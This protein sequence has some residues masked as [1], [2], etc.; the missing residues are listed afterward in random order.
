MSSQINQKVVAKNTLMLYI[1]MSV[2]MI[3]SLYTSRIVLDILGLDDFG[4]YNVVGGVVVMFSFLNVTLTVAIRRFLAYEMGKNKND[5]RIQNVF[6]SCIIAVFI[7]SIIIVIGL[8]SMGLWFLNYQLN[9]PMERMGA[10]NFVFQFSILA[11]FFNLNLIPF[12]SAIVTYEKMDI[13]AYLGIIETL[14]KLALVLSLPILPGDKLK[15]YGLLILGLT[16]FIA[17]CNYM[18]CCSNIIRPISITTFHW[19]YVMSIFKFSAWTVLG[20]MVFM[21][22]TQGVNIIYNLF[23][24]V[25]INAALGIAQNVAGATGQF[26]A[27][28]QTAFNPQLIKIYSTEGLSENTF[29]FVCQTS[30][31]SFLL[32]LVIGVPIIANITPILDLWLVEVPVYAAI[33][34]VIFILNTSIDGVSGPLYLLVYAKGDLKNY[35][36]VL[37]AIQLIY[38]LTVLILCSLGLYPEVVLSFYI[39]SAMVVYAARLFI[40]KRIMHF[41]VYRFIREVIFPLIIPLIFLGGMVLYGIS[42]CSTEKLV[43]VVARIILMIVFVTAILYTVYLTKDERYFVSS[44]FKTVIH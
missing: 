41:P 10:A 3:I 30:R 42:Y 35:Q 16:V 39:V 22:S 4:I 8:E 15:W 26:I 20:S 1:R 28:F 37:S 6:N 7:T 32:V 14:L 17:I 29:K 19:D 33:F 11:F 44:F 38:V 31:L 25:A 12:S 21:L 18:Y 13:Y 2:M 36:I 27:N 24:G 23:Y 5:E 34:S 9:I 40:L 43:L